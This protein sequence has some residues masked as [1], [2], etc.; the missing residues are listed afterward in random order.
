MKYSLDFKSRLVTEGAATVGQF[1]PKS[2]TEGNVEMLGASYAYSFFGPYGQGYNIGLYQSGNEVARFEYHWREGGFIRVQS[3]MYES[4]RNALLCS[5]G[6]VGKTSFT[7]DGLTIELSDLVPETERP[8]L[9]TLVALEVM[10]ANQVGF[11]RTR[12]QQGVPT[13]A[14]SRRG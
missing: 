2:K 12:A 4:S 8:T 14:A 3:A 1:L 7:D 11:T 9:L 5:K 13:D 6:S 10:W